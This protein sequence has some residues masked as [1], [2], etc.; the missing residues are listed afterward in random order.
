MLPIQIRVNGRVVSALVAP[1]ES[2]LDFLR[3]PALATEVKCGCK[4]GDCGTCTV[5]LD[6]LPVKSCLV[7]A[8]QANGHE[9][10]TIRG[11]LEDSLMQRLQEAFVQN[12]AIQ[13]GFCTPGM[14]ISAYSFLKNNNNPTRGQI[15][16]AISG[17]L[18]RC[19]GYKKII[20]AIQNVARENSSLEPPSPLA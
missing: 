8:C 4:Q 19:T 9:V 2:L 3:G 16:E 7:L 12:G 6:D 11:L 15:R 13:C 17:N 10:K 5:L 14:L 1:E 18:C 20:D